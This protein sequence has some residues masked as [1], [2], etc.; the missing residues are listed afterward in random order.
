MFMLASPAVEIDLAQSP[1]P[2]VKRIATGYFEQALPVTLILGAFFAVALPMA[3]I[4]L[5]RPDSPLVWLYLWLFGMTHFIM[6]F[7][8]YFTG[9]NLRHF[10]SSPRT[11]VIFFVLPVVIFVG[12]DLLHAL[13]VGAM[14]P[15]FAVVFWGAIRLFDFIHLTRQTFGVLQLFKGR[16]RMK[17]PVWL[18]KIENAFTL[19]S[20]A[21]LMATFLSGGR[22]PLLQPGGWLSLYAMG[23]GVEDTIVQ[24]PI[25]V[26]QSIWLVLLLASATAFVGVLRGLSHI[27]RQSPDPHGFAAANAYFSL[28]AIGMLAAAFYLP[29]YLAALAMH[30]VE[31]H[32]LM[33]PRC[34]RSVIDS[35][36]CAE[37]SFGWLRDRPVA[38]VATV[39]LLALLVVA[40]SVAGMGM[41][42]RGMASLSQPL[43]YLACIAIFDGIF[44]FHYFI[45]MFIWRFR[46]PH[47]RSALAGMYIAP[48]AKPT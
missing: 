30:Y 1:T 47:F 39:V 2:R 33:V 28:Q 46:D 38:F 12:F 23:E 18:R 13:R 11:I 15:L 31:Y 5:F 8:I 20:T 42:G 24:L 9:Q 32:V 10:A 19:L 36:S 7:S 26:A 4:V 17:F 3:A 34:F 16:T 35:S 37:R 48:A 40:G 21:L 45:E 25:D 43:G 27:R 14:F 29:L 6:T 22:C 44:V 41:M